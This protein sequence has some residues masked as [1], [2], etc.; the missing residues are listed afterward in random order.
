LMSKT[1]ACGRGKGKT[2]EYAQCDTMYEVK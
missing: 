1:F 2:G